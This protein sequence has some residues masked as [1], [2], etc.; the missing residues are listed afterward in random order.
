M[1]SFVYLVFGQ[2]PQAR[3][4]KYTVA[5][6]LGAQNMM[7]WCQI[8]VFLLKHVGALN[9]DYVDLSQTHCDRPT[10]KKKITGW[11]WAQW[12]KQI[13]E[14]INWFDTLLN[15]INTHT[16]TSPAF[17]ILEVFFIIFFVLGYVIKYLFTPFVLLCAS[18]C[19]L[20]S[21]LETQRLKLRKA[22]KL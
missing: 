11:I 5:F 9:P 14:V 13:R 1:D 17:W 16:D 8:L 22:Q 20:F 4:P 15:I 6:P 3:I 12:M 10:M 7:H 21:S 2:C 18:F 19:S